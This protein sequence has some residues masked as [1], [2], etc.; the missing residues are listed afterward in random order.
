MA[1][2]GVCQHCG[3]EV[4]QCG[5][6]GAILPPSTHSNVKYCAACRRLANADY[7]K[8]KQASHR[9]NMRSWRERLAELERQVTER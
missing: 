6:C 7:N 3:Y 2:K 1:V 9:A 5:S 4:K 8:A